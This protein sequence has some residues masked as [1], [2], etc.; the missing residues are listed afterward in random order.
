MF[1]REVGVPHRGLDVG[2]TRI[3]S[4]VLVPEAIRKILDCLGLH[5]RAPPNALA[6]RHDEGE[7]EWS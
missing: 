1:R 4:A 3:L 6:A 5:S 2:V 7:L